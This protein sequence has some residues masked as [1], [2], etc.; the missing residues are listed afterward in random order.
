MKI[1]SPKRLLTNV[2]QTVRN[3]DIFANSSLDLPFAR[4]KTLDPRVT[5][6]RASSATFV[7]SSGVLR[8]AVTNLLLRSEEF[9]TTWSP[10]NITISPDAIAAPNGTLTA[11]KSIAT[12]TNGAHQLFQVT[13]GTSGVTYTISFYVKEGEYN[14]F[15]FGPGNA[16]VGGADK[17]VEINLALSNPIV[18]QEAI[19]NSSAFVISVGNGWYRVGATFTAT[20]T[21][22]MTVAVLQ[23]IINNAGSSSFAGDGT[24]GIYLWGAQ[25]EQA[26][27][28]GEYIPTTSTINSA[29]RFDHNPTTGESLGLLVEEART[30]S[31][32]NNTGV[33]AVAG[34][35]GT[36]PTNWSWNPTGGASTEVVGT[37]TENG[38]AYVDVRLFGTLSTAPSIQFVANTAIAATT[39]QTW[40]ESFYCKIIS[41]VS[42]TPD[43]RLR[44][45]E[46]SVA[47]S[48]L[49]EG[50]QVFTPGISSASLIAS[51][52]TFTRTLT[53]VLTGYVV[54]A[55]LF[56]QV[57]GAIDI[58]LRIGLPQLEQGAFATSPIPTTSATVT[59]AADVA[60]IT[61]S[62]FS[63]WYNQTES[64][65]F[66]DGSTA[67]FTATT[68]FVA[69]NNA[70]STNRLEIRQGRVI[71][72]VTGASTSVTWNTIVSP[73]TFVANTSYK[74][75]TAVSNASH[76]NS[77]SGSLETSSTTIGTIA[78]TQ[79]IFGMRDGQTAPTG[80]SSS[81]IKRLTFWPTRLANT[82][83]Q[84]ITQP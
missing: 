54:P 52:F 49:T 2:F 22:T 77:I 9:G 4:T 70:A 41:L 82:T 5:F 42:G 58:T 45:V 17:V 78:A 56:N 29:P 79:L 40:T 31:I 23:T 18:S 59:R 28:V 21:G 75:A 1:I 24:S 51:R 30:N 44:I 57:S 19:F 10:S 60:S 71:P 11:D 34:A 61:G 14:R 35:P 37:G 6:T 38:I 7:D 25:L 48:Y 72:T 27:T 3:G 67:A 69:I 47:G 68:G 16:A 84:Q 20:A 33:G 55:I 53:N 36:L 66:V 15:K 26:S 64:T 50:N 39:G 83:L 32:A 8:S 76:G 65:L 74:Q 63:S 81:T 13:S 62:N 43:P 12:T 80:G 46:R 73:P